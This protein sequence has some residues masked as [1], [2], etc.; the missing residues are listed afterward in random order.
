M[1][2]PPR[3][4]PLLDVEPS[5]AL[6]WA[7]LLGIWGTI[8]T[9]SSLQIY[10]ARV[11]IGVDVTWGPLLL[12]E[13]PV[14][15]FWVAASI[16]IILLS[17][18]IPLDRTR[19]VRSVASHLVVAIAVAS[20]FVAYRLLWYQAFNPFPYTTG[21][22]LSWFWRSFREFFILGFVLYWAVVGVYHAFANYA[23]F[24]RSEADLSEATLSTLRQQLRPHFLF[25]ALNTVS[26]L[27]ER[28]PR[29]ARRVI[30]RLGDLL[31]ES[32][33]DSRATEVPLSAELELV[34]AYVEIEQARFG[35]RLSTTFAVDP[36]AEDALVPTLLLQPLVENAMR[37]GLGPRGGGHV[38]V[39]AAVAGNQ[40][41][42]AV[43][44]DGVGATSPLVE[45][46][47]GLGNTRRRL[48]TLFGESARVRMPQSSLGGFA[49]ELHLPLHFAP[50]R[51]PA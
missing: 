40:L 13:L 8:G 33:R 42:L 21:T 27:L 48:H 51:R 35:D 30:A 23:R 12:M 38:H 36:Q 9:F 3:H 43:D 15:A 7:I 37:H 49:V 39:T 10:L 31:R 5:P 47:V 6:R 2:N 4:D 41:C 46:G 22:P 45:E 34:R 19:L 25:N 14:W 26:A 18:R 1:T 11:A 17:R 50:L 16:G 20:A 44:D 29:T 28:D 32:L 24:R